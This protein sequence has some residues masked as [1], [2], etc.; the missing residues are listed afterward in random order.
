MKQSAMK[1]GCRKEIHII[2]HGPQTLD[3]KE[4]ISIREKWNISESKKICVSIQRI[5]P[6]KGLQYLI[7]AITI[8]SKNNEDITF[9][10]GGKG[11]EL[12][13]LKKLIKKYKLQDQVI[14]AGFIPDEELS[15]YYEQADLFVLPSLYEGFGLVYLEALKEGTPI[16]T[17]KCG[18]PEDII[19]KD[20]GLL[21]PTK[22]YKKLAEAI[23][24][25]LNKNWDKEKIK[26]DSEKYNWENIFQQYFE[27][28]KNAIGNKQH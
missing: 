8:L 28:Y 6:R 25:A 17:T 14:L 13:R 22:D 21:V 15:S 10:I 11:P 1:Q 2:P 3:K 24:T 26:K 12:E 23:E 5:E 9:I 18:G 4:E 27:L 20:N 19:T 16:V 7:Y